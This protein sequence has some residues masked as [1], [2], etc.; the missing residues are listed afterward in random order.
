MTAHFQLSRLPLVAENMTPDGMRFAVMWDQT[1]RGKIHHGVQIF[2]ARRTD[3]GYEMTAKSVR[4]VPFIES[5]GGFVLF[6]PK[7]FWVT[8]PGRIEFDLETKVV[9]ATRNASL[10]WLTFAEVMSTPVTE[11]EVLELSRRFLEDTKIDAEPEAIAFTASD[12]LSLGWDRASLVMR[13]VAN[14]SQGGYA[15]RPGKRAR[16]ARP[17]KLSTILKGSGIAWSLCIG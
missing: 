17:A 13:L 15:L 11:S 10:A 8:C 5:P 14:V 3:A 1:D 12:Q 4:F 9:Q 7:R 2:G 6:A 16:F